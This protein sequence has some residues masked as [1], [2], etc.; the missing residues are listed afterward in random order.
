MD[1]NDIQDKASKLLRALEDGDA[2][3][4]RDLLRGEDA[5]DVALDLAYEFYIEDEAAETLHELL[6]ILAAER[7]ARETLG[8]AVGDGIMRD[9]AQLDHGRAVADLYDDEA[10]A[11][12]SDPDTSHAAAESV[13]RVTDT[14]VA[15]A[16][17]MRHIGRP[18]TDTELATHYATWHAEFG[19]ETV[20]RSSPSGL[21]T[22]RSELVDRKIV[23][24]S[25]QRELLPSG[26]HAILWELVNPG[27][28]TEMDVEARR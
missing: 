4:A 15:I 12:N 17:L 10:H 28:I 16:D 22:R 19:E 24:D 9:L 1:T 11:R 6:A 21:R 14:Q 25:G 5:L 18:I 20:P 2:Q 27:A 26:R 7:L 13:Q 23:Q 8:R 3:R